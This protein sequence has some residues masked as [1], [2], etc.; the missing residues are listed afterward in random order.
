MKLNITNSV[1]EGV[2]YTTTVTLKRMKFVD[3]KNEKGL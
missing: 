1:T 3:I 2:Y